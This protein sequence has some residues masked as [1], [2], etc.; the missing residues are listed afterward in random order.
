MNDM[1]IYKVTNLLNGKIYIGQTTNDNPNYYGSGTY[2]NRAIKKHGLDIFKKE[3]IA[4][5]N[6]RDALDLLEQQYIKFFNCKVP[7]GYNFTNGGNSGPQLFGD[8]NP[9]KRP[10]VRE[11][12]RGKRSRKKQ[13]SKDGLRRTIE[14]SRKM[15][16]ENNPMNDPKSKEKFLSIVQ[17]EEYKQNMSKAVN[18]DKNG[19]YGKTHSEET[20]KKISERTKI[21][22][23][24]DRIKNILKMKKSEE[25]KLKLSEATKGRNKGKTYE[26]MYGEEKAK[27]LKEKKRKKYKNQYS[28]K[29]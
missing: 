18:G 8:S 19:M 17:S 10:E 28:E 16:L 2:I 3:I 29:I 6:N 27:L 26:E 1:V 4:H 25:T 23:N 15:L 12:L 5:C 7:N 14:S 22:M 20:R 11:K 24:N 21:A 9:S 13:Y